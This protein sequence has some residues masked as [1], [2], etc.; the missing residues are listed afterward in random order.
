MQAGAPGVVG[1]AAQE[2]GKEPRP[3]LT[4]F[5]ATSLVIGAV[6]GADIYVAASLGA[7]MLGPAILVAWA[8]AGAIA[9]LIALSFAQ[10]AAIIP[11]SGG[12]Y[13]Y[14]REALGHPAGFFAG[15]ALYV[16][17]LVGIAI[18]P[19]A[20]VRYLTFFVPALTAAEAA[21]AKVA[22]VAFLVITNIVGTRA[23]GKVNDALTI[24]KLGPLLVLIVLGLAL[25]VVR[26]AVA[27]ANVRPFAPLGWAGLGG[28]IVLAFW[29]YAG[30]ELAVLPGAEVVDAPRT[31]PV[32][33]VVGMAA[34][35]AFYLLV[36][37]VVTVAVPSPTLAAS[38]APLATALEAILLLL[39]V[40]FWPLGGALMALG[41]ILSISGADESAMLGT[42]RLSYAMAAD[43]YLPRVFARLHPRYGTP[44]WGIIVQGLVALVASLVGG[45][46]S[47]IELSVFFLSLAYLATILSAMRLARRQPERRLSVPGARLI[48]LLGIGGSVYLLSQTQL[49]G[50]LV[51]IALLAAGGLVYTRLAPQQE[52]AEAKRGL[53]SAEHRLA[54]IERALRVAPA[55]ALRALRQWGRRG[56][57]AGV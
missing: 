48:P 18:F 10:C 2:P 40:P 35:T 21:L 46:R 20:F 52:L 53:L 14:T 16:A 7:G 9:G 55:N 15:W 28:G 26:P 43:G 27:A 4:L 31:L 5:D 50:L 12:S 49:P 39:L 32:A 51:G 54:A 19:V 45:L 34:A 13:A 24:A 6:I 33:M 1:M 42:S 57:G 8:I 41:A 37:T 29:A 22:F 44:Y 23:A 38:V 17:E 56:P 25:V 47:L 11:R 3:V 30:F 36:N